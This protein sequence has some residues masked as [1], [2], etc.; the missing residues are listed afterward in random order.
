MKPVVVLSAWNYC[1]NNCDYCV[2]KS[3][4]P[5]WT[6]GQG[7]PAPGEVTDFEASKRWINRFRPG[8]AVHISGGEPLLRPDI[9]DCVR[10]FTDA[11]Y[12]TTIFTNGQLLPRRLGLLELP[13]KWVVTYHQDCGVPFDEWLWR[14][15][16]IKSRPHILQTVVA[17]REKYL[18]ALAHGPKLEADGWKFWAKYAQHPEHQKRF[19]KVPR[20]GLENVASNLLTLIVPTDGSVYPCNSVKWGSIG[21]VFEMTMDEGKALSLDKNTKS[22]AK[23]KKCQAILTALAVESLD[24][25]RD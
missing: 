17:D 8:A 3:N 7:G 23:L 2:S 24:D 18:W 9:I 4:T 16:P 1:Q 22:C 15:E 10:L 13:L 20:V 21:N 25:P 19:F 14:V 6:L 5:E 12:D 11:G